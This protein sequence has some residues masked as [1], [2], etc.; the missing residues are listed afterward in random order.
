MLLL[1]DS[2]AFRLAVNRERDSTGDWDLFSYAL[3]GCGLF[4]GETIDADSD[5]PNPARPE[6]ASW[7]QLWTEKVDFVRPHVAVI[8]VGAWEVLDRQVDGVDLRFPS[9]EWSDQVRHEFADGVEIAGSTGAQVAVMSVPCMPDADDDDT[10][11]R[12]DPARVAAVDAIIDEVAATAGA[13]VFDLA[14]VICPNGQPLEEIGGDV[15]R[16]DGVHL[17]EAGV[18]YV[19][20]WLLPQLEVFRARSTATPSKPPTD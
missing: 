15:V 1:G 10:T 4:D 11:A 17:S 20:E 13:T 6:C 18:A 19:W 7:R 14:N 16:Y 3:T 8:M 9:P 5:T 2:T 12:A